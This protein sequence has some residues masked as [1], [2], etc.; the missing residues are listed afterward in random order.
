[1]RTMS[2]HLAS[3]RPQQNSHYVRCFQ[4]KSC[5]WNGRKRLEEAMSQPLDDVARDR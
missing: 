1:M 5:I 2:A 3:R 4:R